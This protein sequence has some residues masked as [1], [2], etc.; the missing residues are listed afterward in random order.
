LVRRRPAA[1]PCSIGGGCIRICNEIQL[2]VSCIV[3]VF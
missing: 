1:V 3:N 2:L